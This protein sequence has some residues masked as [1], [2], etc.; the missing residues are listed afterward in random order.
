M[1]RILVLRCSYFCIRSVRQRNKGLLSRLLFLHE[2][3]HLI[4]LCHVITWC[5]MPFLVLV[6]SLF[7][8]ANKNNQRLACSWVEMVV[9]LLEN[10]WDLILG[11]IRRLHLRHL[12]ATFL[13]AWKWCILFRRLAYCIISLWHAITLSWES[14]LIVNTCCWLILSI[15]PTFLKVNLLL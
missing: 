7:W 11:L 12:N 14:L 3:S 8:A 5:K 9:I 13:N 1:L 10:H 4:H 15:S 6:Y 2:S